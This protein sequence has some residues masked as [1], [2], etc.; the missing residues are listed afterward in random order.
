[1][2]NDTGAVL[3]MNDPVLALIGSR[4]QCCSRAYDTCNQKD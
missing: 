3:T 4:S 1:M 2:W